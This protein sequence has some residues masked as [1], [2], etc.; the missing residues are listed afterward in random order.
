M[1]LET[2]DPWHRE[3]IDLDYL[4]V[5]HESG[6]FASKEVC[7]IWKNVKEYCDFQTVTE[8]GFNCGR[9]T[10]IILNMFDDVEVRSYD[11]CI[12][13]EAML[14]AEIIKEE[15]YDRFT[16]LPYGSFTAKLWHEQ[17]VVKVKKTDLLFVDGGHK[18]P[19]ILNDIDLAQQV[20]F[21]YILFD[22]FDLSYM[23]GHCSE[24]LTE[25]EFVE[26]FFYTGAGSLHRGYY[27]SDDK[28]MS[29]GLYKRKGNINGK[30]HDSR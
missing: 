6:L 20:G 15:F 19:A 2:K 1:K 7:W 25:Y 10:A 5:S 17:N 8:I 22:D 29:M 4:P 11:I 14:A 21:E 18:T 23:R 26:E 12:H 3:E 16:F 24:Y 9:G 30:E 13:P 27:V 28:H